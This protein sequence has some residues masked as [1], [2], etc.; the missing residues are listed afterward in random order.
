M[1]EDRFEEILAAADP[2]PKRASGSPTQRSKA[3]LENAGY[4]VAITDDYLVITFKNGVQASIDADDVEEVFSGNRWCASW[5]GRAWYFVRG[6]RGKTPR[7]YLH[8]VL[9]GV[10]DGAVKVDHWDGDTTNNR[11]GN[12]RICTQQQ[13]TFNSKAKS[14][15]SGYKGVAW[16]PHCRKW[17]ARIMKNG[18][19]LYLGLHGSAEAAAKAYNEAASLHFGEF[20][21]LNDV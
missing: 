13:N 2:K 9:A 15:E 21:R 1:T 8:R 10:F 4:L 17:Q 3:Y 5:S 11:R 12:L 16:V 14:P 20:A 19:T 18:K 6:G 7:Q